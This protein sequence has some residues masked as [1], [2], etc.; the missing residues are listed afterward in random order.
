MKIPKILKT[1]DYYKLTVYIEDFKVNMIAQ[2]KDKTRLLQNKNLLKK[3]L[4][5]L[6][7]V[8][9]KEHRDKIDSISARRTSHQKDNEKRPT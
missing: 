9:K 7:R 5:L 2:E 4:K 8:A 1:Y 3:L 6:A